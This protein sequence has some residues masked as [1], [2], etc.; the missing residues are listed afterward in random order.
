MA[1]SRQLFRCP[2]NSITFEI[3]WL[4]C[5]GLWLVVLMN[6]A[7][8]CNDAITYTCVVPIYLYW[9]LGALVRTHNP[10][11]WC[12]AMANFTSTVLGI[13]GYSRYTQLTTRTRRPMYGSQRRLTKRRRQYV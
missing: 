13:G 2:H 3:L 8:R 9:G 4:L 11:R 10:C 5:A 12:T 7:E 1:S 6:E